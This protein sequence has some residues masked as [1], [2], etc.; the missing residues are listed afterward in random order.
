MGE[1][2]FVFDMNGDIYKIANIVTG[3]FYIGSSVN[4]NKR[5]NRHENMLKNNDHDNQI[6]QNACNKYGINK[7]SFDII[8][9]IENVTKDKLLS[10]EQHYIDT[11]NPKYNICKV[12]GNCLGIK[13]TKKHKQKISENNAKY[14]L[15]KNRSEE[16]KLKLSKSF[17]IKS[18]SGQVIKNKNLSKFCEENNLNRRHM[19]EV[20]NNRRKSHKGWTKE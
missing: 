5:F 9:H 14:W 16:T 7:L 8:E 2:D 6:L 18:P 20:I 11:L 10:R 19:W 1:R 4:I 15:N 17:K 3:D 12:A 13:L